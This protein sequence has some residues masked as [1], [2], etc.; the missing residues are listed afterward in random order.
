MGSSEPALDLLCQPPM[1]PV[2]EAQKTLVPTNAPEP[3]HD[4]SLF[5]RLYTQLNSVLPLRPWN[6]TTGTPCMLQALAK[7]YV[8]IA[9]G[10]TN[11]YAF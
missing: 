3:P 6:R 2:S 8:R 11:L 4:F 10:L 5:I 9:V 1:A 7:S